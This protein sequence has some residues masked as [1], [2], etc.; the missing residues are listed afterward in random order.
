M[1]AL[2]F[3]ASSF[4]RSIIIIITIIVVLSRNYWGGNAPPPVTAALEPDGL[5]RSSRKYNSCTKKRLNSL[6]KYSRRAVV[7]TEV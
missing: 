7:E 2:L 4:D 5:R 1:Y 6:L 3:A